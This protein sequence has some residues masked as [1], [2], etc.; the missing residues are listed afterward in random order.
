MGWQEAY[1]RWLAHRG[2]D[3]LLKKQLQQLEGDEEKLEDCFYKKLEFGTG[4]MRGKIGPGT[5]RMNRY[6]V[7]QA[8]EGLARCVKKEGHEAMKRGVVIAYDSRHQS[9]AFAW[10]AART[11]GKHHIQC[12]LF[13]NLRPT[14][15]LSFAVRY[16]GAFMGIVITASHNPPEYNGYKVYGEDGGQ[17]T[18]TA[19][20]SLIEEIAKVDNEL[21]VAVA[22]EKYLLESGLLKMIGEEIDRVYLDKVKKLVI[23]H[24]VIKE[25][26]KKLAV[27]FTPLH[28]TAGTLV[29]NGL[30]QLGFENVNVVK[31]QVEPDPHFTTVDSPNPEEHK[32]FN[33]AIREGERIEADILLATD[34]DADR[35][36]V[37]VKNKNN[38]YVVL[39]GN[40]TGALMLHYLLSQR[41][42]RGTL[43]DDGVVLKTIVTSELGRK[44][45]AK[46]HVETVDTLTGFKFIGEK[47]G[48]Y[49]AK[50][51]R[52]FLFGYEESYGYLIGDFVRD[53]DAIQAC[54]LACEMAAYYK[55]QGKSLYDALLELYEEYGCHMEELK[56]LKMEGKSGAA[57][58]AEIMASFRERPLFEL[59]EKKVVAVE[60]Y[61]KG[62][63]HFLRDGRKEKLTL[64]ESNVLKYILE[65]GAWFCLRPSGTEPKI[66]F[67][68]GVCEKTPE[69]SAELLKEMSAELL[70]KVE[71]AV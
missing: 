10:E 35:V 71:A 43:P 44:I 53:K 16:L 64:P 11:L 55:M 20:R 47:I 24:D 70:Q 14:P 19:V 56:S 38:Q 6:T 22:D 57:K 46:H 51:N 32:A 18:P 29:Q 21:E 26:G 4:G 30:K 48:E 28:G 42:K 8:T 25:M 66:K 59:C 63:R 37:A 39:T 1:Q 2:L 68:F 58:I 45:A 52:S 50:G 65:D 41:K 31:E 60:D 5:N 12:Y 49:E 17:L 36:G 3:E 61:Q 62:E 15:E 33:L 13:E 27:V 54:V 34:P 67:Y 40:Q 9:A 7:R 23:N 69:D